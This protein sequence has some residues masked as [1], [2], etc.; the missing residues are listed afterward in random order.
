MI[1]LLRRVAGDDPER[2]AVISD[3]RT[4]TYGELTAWAEAVADALEAR[5]IDRFAVTTTD[6]AAISALLAGSSLVRVEACQLAATDSPAEIAAAL[7]RFELTVLVTDREDL[8]DLPVTVLGL[9][10]LAAP[11]ATPAGHRPV[12]ADVRPLM[13][14]T[15]GTTGVP[16]GAR[17]DWNRVLRPMLRL[18]AAPDQVWLLAYG[19]HQFAGLQF[20]M[21]TTGLGGTMVAPR[22]RRPKDAL[23]AMRAHGV[24]HVSATPTW[25]RFLLAELAT[26]GGPAPDLVQIT[27]GGEAVP[28]ALLEQLSATFTGARVSQIYGANEFGLAGSTRDRRSG[29]AASILERG[30]DADVQAKIVDGEL[31]VRTRVGM[32]GYHGEPPLDPEA[33]RPTGDLVEVV[34]DRIHFRGRKTEIIN[35]GGVKVH[36][37]PVEERISAVP[38]VHLVRVFGRENRLTGAI[39]AAEVVAQPGADQD[40]VGAAIRAACDDLPAASR[41][42][43]ITFVDELAVRGGKVSRR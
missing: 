10:D 42:R 32:L 2:L 21:N 23:V 43:S 38:G 1:E 35:V 22:E 33:W 15:T 19:S 30:D 37:I 13:V 31:W 20:L 41:P 3:D 12:P 17:H 29:L 40:E 34:G 24:T 28:Q 4:S 25:W 9:H 7:E 27:L 5:G 8:A 11:G 18:Q 26:D 14:L 39:V 16:K 36:P 6:A